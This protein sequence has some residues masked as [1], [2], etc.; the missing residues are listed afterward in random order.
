MAITSLRSAVKYECDSCHD[1]VITEPGDEPP[2]IG[3]TV[4]EVHST[5]TTGD[6]RWWACKREHVN[7]AII[8]VL[9]KN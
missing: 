3:G 9:E 8:N 4:R 1:G 2:G 5:G 7:Q 6:M